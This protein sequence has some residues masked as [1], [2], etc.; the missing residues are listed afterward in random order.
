[1]SDIVTCDFFAAD[2]RPGHSA[3]TGPRERDRRCLHEDA[4]RSA[5]QCHG[6]H[7]AWCVLLESRFSWQEQVEPVQDVR[8]GDSYV[9][10]W[11]QGMFTESHLRGRPCAL[12]RP[13][14]LAG[15]AAAGF[16]QVSK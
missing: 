16:P 3:A 15:T 6:F 8:E 10:L 2:L 11:W 14:R 12:R 5:E 13:P 1:M 4:I 7:R 9:R